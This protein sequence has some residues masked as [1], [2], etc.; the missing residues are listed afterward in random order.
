MEIKDYVL[1]RMMLMVPTIL[2]V[3]VATFILTRMAGSPVGLYV[4]RYSSADQVEAVREAY[5]LND[6]LYV[7][8][9]YW[10]RGVVVDFDLGWSQQANMP[11]TD[12]LAHFAPA[13]FELAAAGILIA[14]VV[15]VFLGTLAG[16]HPD[17]WIDHLSRAFA[18]GGMSTPQFWAALLLIFVGYVSLGLFPLG[19]ANS[20]VWESIAHPTG[21]YT[22]DAL[23]AMSP[24][25]L[26][27]ALWH[28]ILPASVIGYA[29]SAVITRHLRSEIIEKTR[30]EY[31]D[32]ARARGLLEGTVYTKHV[33]RN[34]LIPTVTVAGLSFAF[35]LRGIVVVELVFAWPGMG[36]WVANAAL[37]GDFAAIMGFILVVA[38]IVLSINLAV[39]VLYAYLDP[40]IEL[41]E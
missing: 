36:R 8:F 21:L 5:H 23:I 39:D 15:S 25:A 26:G 33:R 10:L 19:R 1:R 38:V 28:L 3:A 18:V 12:A 11:V 35:L 29:E 27:D 31:V 41:G 40:R 14:T 7:Q 17:T 30:E 16:R 9:L 34:A 2:L 24:R 20:A 6:P 4:S 13:T 22:V 37:S 32:A